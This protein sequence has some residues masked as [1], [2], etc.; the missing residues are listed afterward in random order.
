MWIESFRTITSLTTTKDLE[1]NGAD[2]KGMYLNFD[3]D[4]EVYMHQPPGYNDGSSCI[5][6]LCKALYGLKQAGCTWNSKFN[7]VL[8]PILSFM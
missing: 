6:R 8:T 5:L 3:L 7:N 4:K 2:I 1:V